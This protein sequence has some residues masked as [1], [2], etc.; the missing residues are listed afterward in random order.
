LI[1]LLV[2]NNTKEENPSFVA[3]NKIVAEK[4]NALGHQ[5]D[6]RTQGFALDL[7]DYDAVQFNRFYEGS[8]IKEI[9]ALKALGKKIIYETDDNYDGID[10]THPFHKIAKYAKP[11]WWE[12]VREA[13][14][15]IVSTPYLE[16]RMRSKGI[17]KRI[18]VIPNSIDLTMYP[19]RKGRNK[20]LRIGFQ[21]SNIHSVD[22][23]MV[24]DAIAD[25]QK[26]YGFEFYI[27]GID[28]KPFKKLY[29][30]VTE[31][32]KERF[33]WTDAFKGLYEKLQGM[34]YK[35]IPT[36]P[37]DDYR[38]K[39]AELNL[40]IG[41][42][43]LK[44]TEFNRAKSCL[45][46]YEYAAVM[47]CVLASNVIPYNT[48]MSEEDLVKNRYHGWK[49]KLRK[50]IED[51]DYRMKRTIEQINWL[52]KNRN[53]ENMKWE[54]NKAYFEIIFNNNKKL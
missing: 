41:I 10:E 40:D 34:K 49:R 38:K 25:L 36:V 19:E 32:Y 53:L 2:V 52:A 9:R 31:E 30:F 51:K 45:K 8:L 18:Y 17:A 5:I 6:C 14:A 47:T 42:C 35:H 44:D 27:F 20:K 48:E 22:L 13:D 11:S 26:E 16:E 28:D 50:L 46:F 4:L 7:N 29:K 12:L 37:Y 21:G 43:P 3:R 23:L 1:R 15:I 54:W 24:I 39:L 33:E